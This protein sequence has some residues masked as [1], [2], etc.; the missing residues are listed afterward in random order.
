MLAKNIREMRKEKGITQKDLAKNEQKGKTG[1]TKMSF[2]TAFK[3]SLRNLATKKGRTVLT[4]FAGSIGII[5]IALILAVSQGT[6]SYINYVQESTLSAYPI[7]LE[8]ESVDLT[9]LMES[10]MNVGKGETTHDKDA[11][12]KDQV[13]AELVNALAKTE[14]SENDLKSFKIYLENQLKKED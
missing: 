5:G 11:I 12:Y 1:R 4:T 2:W 9:A 10:F 14:T 13:I 8:E 6:S 7:T 3:L